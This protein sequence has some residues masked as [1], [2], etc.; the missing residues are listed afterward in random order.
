MVIAATCCKCGRTRPSQKNNGVKWPGEP[1]SGEATWLKPAGL[2]QSA[3]RR[4]GM[5]SA[6]MPGWMDKHG[7]A[8]WKKHPR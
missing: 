3:T 7:E 4:A 1:A 8:F 6:H 2:L 5:R